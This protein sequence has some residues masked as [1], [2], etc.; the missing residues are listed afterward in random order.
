MKPT[1]GGDIHTSMHKTKKIVKKPPHN[2][3]SLPVIKEQMQALEDRFILLQNRVTGLECN[4]HEDI[5]RLVEA[6]ISELRQAG[7]FRCSKCNR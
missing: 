1:E 4:R 6:S 7:K 2:P 5:Q 3:S